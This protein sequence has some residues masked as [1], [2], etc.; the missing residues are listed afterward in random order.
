[1]ITTLALAIAPALFAAPAQQA[2]DV[3]IEPRTDIEFANSAVWPGSKT[4]QSLMGVG[5]R[6]KTFLRVKVY[7]LGLYVDP[8]G[9]N[10]ALAK[11]KDT[12]VKKVQKDNKYYDALLNGD[13]SKTL[14]WVFVRDVD[15]EDIGD[16]FEDSLEPRLADLAKAGKAKKGNEERVAAGEAGLK[17]LK[18]WFTKELEDGHELVFA[19]HPGGKLTVRHEGKVI[20]ELVSHNVCV[21]LFDT[22]IGEDTVADDA[23]DDFANGRA[24]IAEHAAR[25]KRAQKLAK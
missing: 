11:W 20:G 15:G 17:K 21:A 5:V 8:I 10:K 7:A 25:A 9:A 13:F 4:A 2:K 19:W 24:R 1:M 22:A 23:R 16:A 14:R 12:S 6:D 18:S 3:T